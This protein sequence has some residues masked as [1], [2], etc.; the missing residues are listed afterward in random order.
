M[1]EKVSPKTT[2][3]N[4]LSGKYKQQEGNFLG[5]FE[6][7]HQDTLNY[8]SLG[9]AIDLINQIGIA[10]IETRINELTVAARKAFT[11]RGLL[12]ESVVERKE[13][14]SIFNIKG[15]NALVAHLID[16]DILCIARGNG[17][18]VSFHYFNTLDDLDKL[19]SVLDAYSS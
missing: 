8:G 14:S 12:E 9:A 1:A 6:P 18:R 2:G 11:E 15:D 13:H 5:R 19:L 7:G 17:I 10:A 4:S 3:F 16:N